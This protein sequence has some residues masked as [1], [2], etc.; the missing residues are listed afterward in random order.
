M[1]TENRH[2]DDGVFDTFPILQ[3]LFE[4]HTNVA[5]HFLQISEDFE[6]LTKTFQDNS[7]IDLYH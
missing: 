7:K 4:D 5:E 1:K 2:T 3:N 6:R